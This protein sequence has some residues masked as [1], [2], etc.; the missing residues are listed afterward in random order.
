MAT[1][2]PAASSRELGSINLLLLEVLK[3]FHLEQVIPMQS[4]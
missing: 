4:L 2:V 3:T 1:G